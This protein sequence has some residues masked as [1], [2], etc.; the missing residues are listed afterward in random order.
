[1]LVNITSRLTFH[2]LGDGLLENLFYW[3]SDFNVP[4]LIWHEI[5]N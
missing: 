1:M 5:I 4:K 2:T 3:L